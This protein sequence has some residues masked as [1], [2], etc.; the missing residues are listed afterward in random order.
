MRGSSGTQRVD[1]PDNAT[2]ADL[3]NKVRA[4]LHLDS[5]YSAGVL[6]RVLLLSIFHR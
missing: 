2:L 5:S 6:G 1:L 3:K 4:W